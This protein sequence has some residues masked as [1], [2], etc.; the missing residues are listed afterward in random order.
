M[1]KKPYKSQPGDFEV[2]ILPDGRVY[3]VAADEALFDVAEA[4]DPKN[5]ALLKRRK[6]KASGAARDPQSN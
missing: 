4:L 6:A 1:K 3:M 2:R 5:P